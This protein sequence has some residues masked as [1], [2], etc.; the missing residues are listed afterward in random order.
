MTSPIALPSTDPLKFHAICKCMYNNTPPATPSATNLLP[1]CKMWIALGKLGMCMAQNTIVRGGAAVPR[2]RLRDCDGQ[3][4]VWTCVSWEQVA[5]VW[6]CAVDAAP[7]GSRW[8]SGLR[9]KMGGG[10]FGGMRVRLGGGWIEF[11]RGI[12]WVLRG[13]VFWLVGVLLR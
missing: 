1:L 12:L 3:V 8:G 9:G 7:E 10:G 13:V 2:R 6:H 5:R 11:R 4:G